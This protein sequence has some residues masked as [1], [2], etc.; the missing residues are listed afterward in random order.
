MGIIGQDNE[1][2][3]IHRKGK[4][5]EKAAEAFTIFHS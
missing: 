4:I 3:K 2:I 1:D 5:T